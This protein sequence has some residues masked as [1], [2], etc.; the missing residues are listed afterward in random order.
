MLNLSEDPH[1]RFNPLTQQ[2]VLVS[3]HRTKR[4]WQGRIDK[5]AE[6][7]TSAYDA[8]CYLCPGNQR[9]G[10]AQNPKYASTFVFDN[11][12]GALMTGTSPDER[13]DHGIIRAQGEPGICR[14]I[15][16]SPRHDLSLPLMSAAEIGTVIDVWIE[17]YR[18]L[19]SFP[20]INHVLIFENR[21]IQMGASN[22][23]PH[24]QI[25]ANASLPNEPLRE[26]QSQA[27]HLHQRGAC[28]LCGYL[29]LELNSRER[30]VCQNADFVAVVPFWAAW[31]FETLLLSKRH[32]SGMDHLTSGERDSLADILKLLTTRYDNLFETAFPYSMGFHQR[33]TDGQEHPEWHF[34][35]HFYPPLLRSATIPKF[36]VGYEMLGAPQ[37][38]LTPENAAERLRALSDVRYAG[39]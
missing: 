14:V 9:A 18:D 12:F 10:G 20:W 15:C 3:P 33:P 19:G 35:A 11:D 22:P 4:P 38:D 29:A 39:R 1:R 28:L 13:N 25:W 27:D 32:V 23:H 37:R 30:L 7:P 36:M 34:H 5:P 16:F 31:P 8:E 17:Q 24:C 6:R 2:W 26:Q 21:G